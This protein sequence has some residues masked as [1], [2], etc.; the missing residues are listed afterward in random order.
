MKKWRDAARRG[1]GLWLAAGVEQAGLSR[2]EYE[3]RCS[4]SCDLVSRKK[5]G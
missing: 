3:V 5:R 4:A 1:A 2:N